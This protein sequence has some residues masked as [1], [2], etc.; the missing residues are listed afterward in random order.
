MTCSS[1]RGQGVVPIVLTHERPLHPTLRYALE[2]H[3][4]ACTAAG[5]ISTRLPIG[6]L[7][8]IDPLSRVSRI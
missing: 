3:L 5:A 4:E 2:Q 7:G 6:P 8:G 1:N